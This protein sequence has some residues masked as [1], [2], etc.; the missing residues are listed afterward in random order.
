MISHETGHPAIAVRSKLGLEMISERE[1]GVV[2]SISTTIP[3]GM[4]L[5]LGLGIRALTDVG[6][7]RAI[8]YWYVAIIGSS[9][10]R[11]THRFYGLGARYGLRTSVISH[12]QNAQRGPLLTTHRHL[13]KVLK[14][15]VQTKSELKTRVGIIPR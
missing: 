4:R 10:V 7:A 2:E 3:R 9:E 11:L 1:R 12:S 5:A 6:G 8:V 15:K 14:Y 13:P